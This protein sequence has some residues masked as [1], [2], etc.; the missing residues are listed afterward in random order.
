MKATEQLT[1]AFKASKAAP[2]SNFKKEGKR[3][4]PDVFYLRWQL[5]LTFALV[6][7]IVLWLLPGWLNNK[8]AMLMSTH[9]KYMNTTWIS[10]VC[11]ILLIGFIIYILVRGSWFFLIR[12]NG[13]NT[14]TKLNFARTVDQVAEVIFSICV[15]I[16]T[17]MLLVSL[18]QF[19]AALLKIT[20][21]GRIKNYS[22]VQM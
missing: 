15:F 10:F 5:E 12:K 4:L 9:N 1:D 19:L 11:N 13:R 14:A 17:M 21:S 3:L 2:I 20:V 18:V 8:V 16:L 22:G 6:A 7:T